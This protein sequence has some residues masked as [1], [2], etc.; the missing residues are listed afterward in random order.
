ME[1]IMNDLRKMRIEFAIILDRCGCSRASGRGQCTPSRCFPTIYKLL[2]P[3]GG[4]NGKSDM[5]RRR[6][7][8]LDELPPEKKCPKCGLDMINETTKFCYVCGSY[9]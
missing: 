7:K 2:Y 9:K 3:K 1:C 4:F 6:R 5:A 8:K